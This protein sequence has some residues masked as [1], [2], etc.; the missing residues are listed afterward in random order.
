MNSDA[1]FSFLPHERTFAKPQKEIIR[2]YSYNFTNE[3]KVFSKQNNKV[4][5]ILFSEVIESQI[6]EGTI[7]TILFKKT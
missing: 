7:C 5:L 1:Y 4:F 3:T 2:Y 6:R